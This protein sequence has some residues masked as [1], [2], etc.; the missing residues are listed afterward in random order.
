MLK[1][2]DDYDFAMKNSNFVIDLFFFSITKEVKRINNYEGILGLCVVVWLSIY[3]LSTNSTQISNFYLSRNYK[4]TAQLTLQRPI[5]SRTLNPSQPKYK[6]P[7]SLHVKNEVA[8]IQH[9]IIYNA[10][11]NSLPAFR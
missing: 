1:A 11:A 2:S 9:I 6:V 7:R 5:E 8:I 3:M 4:Y 10:N